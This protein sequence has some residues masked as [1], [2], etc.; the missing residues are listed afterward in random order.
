MF[1]LASYLPC[2][3]NRIGVRPAAAFGKRLAAHDTTL[4]MWRAGRVAQERRPTGGPARRG[5]LVE[6]PQAG[7][8]LAQMIV[9]RALHYE[10]VALRDFDRADAEAL[11]DVL[12]RVHDNIG[13]LEEEGRE[14][15][16]R[17]A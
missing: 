12:V 2:L 16:R 5:V 8:R 17:S 7:A 1:D 3:V 6:L 9:P 10:E 14:R 15:A 4:P 11:K 13:A